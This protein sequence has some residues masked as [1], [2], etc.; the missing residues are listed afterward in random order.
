MRVRGFFYWCLWV[1]LFCLFLVGFLCLFM[2]LCVLGGG[3]GI[4]GGRVYVVVIE[5]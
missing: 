1:C 4:V 2:G 3:G 5:L